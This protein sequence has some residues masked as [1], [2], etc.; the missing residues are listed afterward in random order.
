VINEEQ[1]R[2]IAALQTPEEEVVY[3]SMADVTPARSEFLWW[4]YLPLG[5]IVIVAGAPGNGKSQLA[6]LLAAM[7]SRG[8]LYPSDVVKPSRT[9]MLCAEDDLPQTVV[10]RLMAVNAD[11]RMVDTVNV[12]TT[13]ASG[14]V[15]AHGLIKMPGDVELVHEWCKSHLDGRLVVFDP[16]ASFFERT[17]STLVNQDVRDVLGPL[18]AVATTYGVTVVI[19]LHLN[20]SESRDFAVRIAESHGLQALARSVLVLGPDPDDPEGQRGSKK[21]I[22]LTKA[23]LVKPGNYGLRCEVRSVTLPQTAP[24]IE[25]S[26]LVLTGKCEINPD[27]LLMPTAE[28]VTRIEAADWLAEFVGDRWVKVSD[29]RSAAISDGHSWRTIDRVRSSFGYKAAKQVGVEHGPWWM[30]K[31]RT[32]SSIPGSVV[33]GGLDG[34]Q[35]TTPPRTTEGGTEGVGGDL[36]DQ[37]R[38][39]ANGANTAN[40]QRNLD[41]YRKFRDRML[42]ERDDDE[43][44]ER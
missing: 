11:L 29:V 10:P 7:A 41:E 24:P 31:P 18:R 9:L 22:A 12:M 3:T 26:E 5:K 28:R 37:G 19:I 39:G 36:G 2:K 35:D 6:A 17:Y 30:A 20:K 13:Y 4:P 8:M 43:D 40:G 1:R 44:D 34:D 21:I 16:V 15:D 33:L 32:T 38:N 14:L 27:D 42:G 23:N 25:T